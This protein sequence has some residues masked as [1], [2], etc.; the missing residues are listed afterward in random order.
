[1][2]RRDE[3]DESESEARKLEMRCQKRKQSGEGCF[4]FFGFK[5]F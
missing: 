2:V 3:V 4:R 1:M 5:F